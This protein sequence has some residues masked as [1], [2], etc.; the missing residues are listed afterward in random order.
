MA[1]STHLL[2]QTPEQL[3]AWFT[4]RGLPA[5]R[6]GQVR[7]WVFQR[8]AG[9]FEEMTDLPKPLRGQ[10]AAE[11]DLWTTHIAAHRKAE[12]GTEKLLLELHDAQHVECVLL[13]NDRGHC[14]ICISSQVG[15]GMGCA[16]APADSTA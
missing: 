16:F 7:K 11:F 5:F 10:L 13:R 1:T 3:R 12:D 6:A 15:C 14:A 8:R 2:A 9:S 4:D